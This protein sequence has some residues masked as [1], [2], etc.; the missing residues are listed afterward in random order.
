MYL[1]N[2]YREEDRE[3][4]LTFLRENNFAI[5]VTYD[6]ERPIATHTPAEVVEREDGG[7]TVYTHM[8]RANPQWKTFNEQEALMIFPGPHT[9]ISA[10]WYNH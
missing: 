8:S 1:P 4:I 9:Y 5:L 6:G 3:T 2:L 7:L 10:R